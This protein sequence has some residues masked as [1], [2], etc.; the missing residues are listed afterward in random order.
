MDDVSYQKDRLLGWT[1]FRL[2][3]LPSGLR[4]LPLNESGT[5]L[6]TGAALLVQIDMAWN[7]RAKTFCSP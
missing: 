3:H 2:D 1:C 6:L 4:L 5:Q 7:K